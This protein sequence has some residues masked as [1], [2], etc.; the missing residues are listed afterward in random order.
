MIHPKLIF[1]CKCGA[2]QAEIKGKPKADENCHCH[3]CVASAQFVESKPAYDGISMLT[4]EGGVAF[5]LV[6]GNIINFTSDILSEEARK[7]ID[8]VGEKGKLARTYCKG[9]GTMI[10]GFKSNFAFLNRRAV[11]NEDG[12]PYE[13]SGPVLNIMKKH[14]FDPVKVPEPSAN[15][16]P[17]SGILGFIPLLLGF[18]GKVA[19]NDS[20]LYCSKD[21]MSKIEAVPI[22]WE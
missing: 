4:S 2:I 17:F 7:N 16:F 10:G 21:M 11:F 22:T 20:A 12:T 8:F 9:C 18:G 1:K 19:P 3:S 15:T 14:A 6:K 13:P 5:S